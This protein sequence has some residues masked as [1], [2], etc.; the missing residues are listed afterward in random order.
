[1]SVVAMNTPEDICELMRTLRRTI[2]KVQHGDPRYCKCGRELTRR[3]A[4]DTCAGCHS[5][6]ALRRRVE[7]RFA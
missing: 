6:A 5:G 3:A 4:R 7:R 1:M 2:A